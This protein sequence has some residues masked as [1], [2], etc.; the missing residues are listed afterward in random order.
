M[1]SEH[2][3]SNPFIFR[4]RFSA[5]PGVSF[6][7]IRD[8][9]FAVT[10]GTVTKAKRV[11]GSNVLRE[12]HVQPA[13][14][15]DVT[16]T[17][18]GGRDCSTSGAI[19]T[20]DGKNLAH[21]VTATVQGPPAISVADA[22]VEEASGATLDFAVTLSR[23]PF[24][25]VTV[26]Y[27]TSDG[28][29]TAAEDYTAT[30]GTLTFTAGE[31]EKIV[32]VPVLDDAHDEDEETLT[33]TLSNPSGGYI[34]DGTATGTI[35]N[36]DPMPQA[37]LA[38]FGRTVTDQVLEAVS[39][40]IA[41][42]RAAGFRGS[43][44][45][46]PVSFG[47]DAVPEAGAGAGNATGAADDAEAVAGLEA[48]TAWMGGEDGGHDARNSGGQLGE[49]GMTGREVL[50]GSSFS[51]TGGSAEGGY[52]AAWGRMAV[53]G[54]DGR[55][56][57]LTLDGE[58]VTGM[59][60]AD[61]A[62]ERWKAGLV[63]S[64][65]EGDGGYDSPEGRGEVSSTLTALH[66]WGSLQVSERLSLWAAAGYGEG[67]LDLK[68]EGMDAIGTDMSYRMGAGGLVSELLE[69]GR[70]DGARFALRTDARFTTTSSEA[71][72][73]MAAAEA[74]TWL[75]RAGLEGSRRFALGADGAAFVPSFEVGLRRDGGDAETGFGADV[76][77]GL[78]FSAPASGLT[79]DVS[80]RGLLAHEASGFREWG[81]SASFGYDPD[82]SPHGLTASL[83]QTWGAAPAG[84]ADALLG[85][86]TMAG[87][88]GEGG[89]G[90]WV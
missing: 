20:G 69:P 24:G 13:G 56:E 71:A 40:R 5:A 66:P 62:A 83:R 68:P 6:Q 87:L 17:L 55:E 25:T 80:A 27:A 10:G 44:G 23:A 67:T 26:D 3:G 28:T 57:Y 38:R 11:E 64:R 31:T 19:C 30:S 35:E 51:L 46:Q 39:E 49:Y 75:L 4:T 42:P 82:P 72:D 88:E 77:G 16:I 81:A 34:A 65:S 70:E 47:G 61:F 41:G 90:G 36:S 79:M 33:L 9:W 86:S 58:V 14:N 2:D 37:W 22:R 53:S 21:T 84:G 8:A 7:T 18:E 52:V 45:G 60:G 12:I 89:D 78:A 29:A 50:L 1:P 54:F 73:G 32:A 76:G 59:L 63:V 15:A 43:L 74:D 85:R 48:L